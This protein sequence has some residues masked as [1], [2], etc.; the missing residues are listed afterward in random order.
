MVRLYAPSDIED[1]QPSANSPTWKA[2]RPRFP[3]TVRLKSAGPKL[4]DLSELSDHRDR[5]VIGF[6][7]TRTFITCSRQRLMSKILR[8][9]ILEFKLLSLMVKS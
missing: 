3:G 4:P 1:E 6:S 2:E 5:S 8:S 9:A 7:T